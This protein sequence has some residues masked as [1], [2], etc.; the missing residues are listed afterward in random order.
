MHARTHLVENSVDVHIDLA[1]VV[2]MCT[3]IHS[4]RP[5]DCVEILE[6]SPRRIQGLVAQ[7]ERRIEKC[8]RRAR[9]REVDVE[10]LSIIV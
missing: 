2:F 3:S 9:G 10:S 5:R 4:L 6:M 1:R 8:G 7:V